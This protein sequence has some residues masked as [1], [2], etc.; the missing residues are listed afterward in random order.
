MNDFILGAMFGWVI[1]IFL[2]S[3]VMATN[4]ILI[5]KIR[6]ILEKGGQK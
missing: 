4:H 1:V 3:M 5:P 6:N 2:F